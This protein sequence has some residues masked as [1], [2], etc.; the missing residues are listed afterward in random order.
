MGGTGRGTHDVDRVLIAG[1][2]PAAVQLAVALTNRLGCVVGIAG[3][4][5]VRAD[6]FFSGLRDSH[7]RIRVDVQSAKD[8][9]AEGECVVDDLFR[10]Y[11]SVT[12]RWHTLVLAVTAD[13]YT[14]V[15]RQLEHRVLEQVRCVVLVSPTVGSSGLVRRLLLGH[16]VDAEVISLSS[17]LG[18]TRWRDGGPSPRVVTAA[19]KK[20][21][22]V[23]SSRGRSDNLDALCELHRRLGVATPVMAGPMAAE[24]RNISL[25]VHPALFMNDITLDAVFAESGPV[26][27]VYKLVP[28]GPITPALISELVSQWKELTSMVGRLGIPGVNLLRF[29]V[30]DSYPVREES[31][32]RRDIERFERLPTI[33]Q[34]YL[35]YV[36]YASLLVDPFSEPDADG[37]YFDFSAVP[38]RRAFVDRAGRWDVPRMPN[39]D[40]YRTKIIQGVGRHLGVPCPTIDRFIAR[41]ER[42][43]DEAAMARAGTPVSAAFSVRDFRADL[44]LI[45][46]DLATAR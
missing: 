39:E 5:S 12:G 9:A 30:E 16:G 29:M 28:E 3:R 46:G 38:I 11:R 6:A 24:T 13:A 1:T 17:Y 2:G 34:E 23:G 36:R 7:G 19:V 22:Y 27:Y 45:R 8:R 42:A 44:E 14:Q 15:V 41:Y 37:R 26:K 35:V 10:G 18:A 25:Y 21:L 20:R 33:H 32:A 43:L 31:V 40:Y 4:E